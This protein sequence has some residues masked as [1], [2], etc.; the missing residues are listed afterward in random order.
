[1]EPKDVTEKGLLVDEET[2]AAIQEGIASA[3]DG[4]SWTFEEALELFR[5][6][7]TSCDGALEPTHPYRLVSRA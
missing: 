2:E 5:V 7:H 6:L 1:M 3:D 4:R